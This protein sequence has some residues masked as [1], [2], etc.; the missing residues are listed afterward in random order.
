MPEP[1][2]EVIKYLAAE[3]LKKA[4]NGFLAER[5]RRFVRQYYAEYRETPV[6]VYA[7]YHAYVRVTG[8]VVK[9]SYFRNIVTKAWK[10][11]ID[12][13]GAQWV[14]LDKQFKLRIRKRKV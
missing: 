3:A 14:H 6:V 5:I 9:E 8:E 12:E 10:C 1:L 7:L 4:D 11:E 13:N 2:D